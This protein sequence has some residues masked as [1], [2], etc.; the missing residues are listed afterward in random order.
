[1]D[2]DIITK[3]LFESL[4][5]LERKDVEY[6]IDD[7]DSDMSSYRDHN[8]LY[9]VIF[10]NNKID[11]YGNGILQ[12]RIGKKYGCGVR[13]YFKY[14]VNILKESEICD[15]YSVEFNNKYDIKWF[16]YIHTC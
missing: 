13:T 16:I 2:L 15:E 14:S 1:M 4:N 7:I 3:R 5:L 12:I 11:K 9:N 6:F 8:K 10:G